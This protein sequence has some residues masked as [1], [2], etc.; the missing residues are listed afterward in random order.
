M[1]RFV[2][3]R[4]RKSVVATV[5]AMTVLAVGWLAGVGA[6]GSSP[7]PRP[8]ITTVVSTVTQTVTQTVAVTTR[9]AGRA[10]HAR[11]RRKGRR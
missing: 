4:P 9:P 3:E 11:H 2:R 5:A 7:R 6:A 8:E 10:V 1:P